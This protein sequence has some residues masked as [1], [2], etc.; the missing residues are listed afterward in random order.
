MKNYFVE[1]EFTMTKILKRKCRV[2]ADDPK[3]INL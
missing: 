2:D 3:V 1:K